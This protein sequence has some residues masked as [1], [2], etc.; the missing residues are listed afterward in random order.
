MT[1]YDKPDLMTNWYRYYGE[2]GATHELDSVA[3][4]VKSSSKGPKGLKSISTASVERV[5]TGIGS[6]MHAQ[7]MA[8][9]APEKVRRAS[10]TRILSNGGTG[11]GTG[12]GKLRPEEISYEAS[13]TYRDGERGSVESESS[14]RMIIKKGVEWSVEHDLR[15]L[16]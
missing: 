8:Q 7:Y 3:S 13:V 1:A 14:R 15:P 5:D 9:L 16:T 6:E 12:M 4:R 11:L 10:K 2:T